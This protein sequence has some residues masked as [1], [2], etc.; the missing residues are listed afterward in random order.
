VLAANVQLDKAI[1]N[2]Q[3]P[4]FYPTWDFSNP[5]L[6]PVKFFTGSNGAPAFPTTGRKMLAVPNVN[7]SVCITSANGNPLSPG[8]TY[9]NSPGVDNFAYAYCSSGTNTTN[10]AFVPA[11]RK[12][13]AFNPPT[14]Q[15]FGECKENI[16]NFLAVCNFVFDTTSQPTLDLLSKLQTAG[17]AIQPSGTL[18]FLSCSLFFEDGSVTS[19]ASGTCFET[20]GSTAPVVAKLQAKQIIYGK[21]AANYG[22][23]ISPPVFFAANYADTVGSP[24]KSL[25]YKP[26][27][28]FG[29]YVD[30][31][32]IYP[33]P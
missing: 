21:Q 12:L 8:S 7:S 4:V 22:T 11:G 26:V 20:P 13:L 5:A 19:S 30:K 9:V 23:R 15:F 25:V 24:F 32:G 33:G 3:K 31:T 27:Q 28:S 1:G 17:G 2:V 14:L 16:A 6:A 10:P 18:S 29:L